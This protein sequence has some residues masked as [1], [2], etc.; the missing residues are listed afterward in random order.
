MINSERENFFD[1]LLYA[2]KWKYSDEE[3]LIIFDKLPNHI[4]AGELLEKAVM[5]FS[6]KKPTGKQLINFAWELVKR[7]KVEVKKQVF[8]GCNNCEQG[9]IKVVNFSAYLDPEMK[10]ISLPVDVINFIH[11]TMCSPRDIY[12][13]CTNEKPSITQYLQKL[14]EIQ[15]QY[16]KVYEFAYIGLYAYARLWLSAKRFPE[17]DNFNPY[18]IWGVHYEDGANLRRQ[19]CE[20]YGYVLDGEPHLTIK[21]KIRKIEPADV[22][23]NHKIYQ[24]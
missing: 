6:D 16:P 22:K 3:Q 7:H 5:K 19:D 18:Q 10:N 9:I 13:T 11:I 20:H 23:Y 4:S 24:A 14:Q 1:S 8:E 17:I 12:C 2:V 21:P 15:Y